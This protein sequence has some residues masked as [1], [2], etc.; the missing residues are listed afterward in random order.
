MRWREK[1]QGAERTAGLAKITEKTV[2][3]DETVMR[4]NCPQNPNQPNF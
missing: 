2:M 1:E 4:A 3:T